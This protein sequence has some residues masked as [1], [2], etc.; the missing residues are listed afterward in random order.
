MWGLKDGRTTTGRRLCTAACGGDWEETFL[1]PR[2]GGFKGEERDGVVI[3]RRRC[4]LWCGFE[5]EKLTLFIGRVEGLDHRSTSCNWWVW[6]VR[7]LH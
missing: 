1:K 5:G 2:E 7:D 4:D 6:A 3:E